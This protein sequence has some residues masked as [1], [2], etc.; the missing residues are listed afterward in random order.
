V[1]PA[2]RSRLPSR[3]VIERPSVSMV[4][5]FAGPPAALAALLER[6]GR[7]DRRSG[8]ELIVADN[9]PASVS[10]ERAGARVLA[11]PE[12]GTPAFARNR[13]AR[14]ASCEWLVFIDADTE[15]EPALLDGYFEPPPGA[16]TAVLA[17]AIIDAPAGDGIAAR[18]SAA[19][20][21]MS[22]LTTLFREGRP[23]AQTANCAVRR[24][25][26]VAVGGFEEHARAGEDADLCFRL[27]AAGWGIEHRPEASVRHR[28]R[29]TVPRL[30]AQ[31]ARHG[32]GAGWLNR[33]YPGE[34]PP[35]APRSLAARTIRGAAAV[36][37]AL[38]RRDRAAVAL[39]AL[40]LLAAWAFDVGRL[41]SNLVSVR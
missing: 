17:G 30:L 18:H 20:A 5:P 34:F 29:T 13:G 4:V 1:A 22:E 37:T 9:G 38:A 3:A 41:R 33:R 16:A 25:A 35:P 10:F 31:L 23:Y 12:I 7:L 36:V 32:S 19:R 14:E 21:H 27:V 26:F 6:L 11:A 2:W 39:S 24:T 28:T 8:D 15:P 40:D